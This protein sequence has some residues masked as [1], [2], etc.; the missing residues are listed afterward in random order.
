MG[1]K[2]MHMGLQKIITAHVG[3]A[4]SSAVQTVFG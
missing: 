1:L 2:H 3:N 4:A